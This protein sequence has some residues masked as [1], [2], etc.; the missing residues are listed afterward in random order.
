MLQCPSTA[1]QAARSNTAF[2]NISNAKRLILADKKYYCDINATNKW[3]GDFTDGL[4]FAPFRIN[5]AERFEQNLGGDGRMRRKETMPVGIVVERR[6]SDHPWQDHY[7]LPVA[8]IPGAKLADPAAPW[9]VLDE[10]EGWVR[11]HAGTL[12]V[13]MYRSDT[14]AYRTNLTNDPPVV[15]VVLREDDESEHEFVPFDATVSAY[16]AQDFADAG[17][18]LVEGV[19]M[20]DV[21]I[22]WVQAFIDSHHVDEPFVKRKFRKQKDG[23]AS[24]AGPRESSW[25]GGHER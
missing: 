21:M 25:R 8:V 9:R 13:D 20:P 1:K 6:D 5:L 11:Y 3:P 19:P 10:G 2:F 7:W 22:A 12:E 18:N 4:R 23:G 17:E 24:A 14:E 16:E 15:Y